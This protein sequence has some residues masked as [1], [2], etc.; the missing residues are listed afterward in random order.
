MSNDKKIVSVANEIRVNNAIVIIGAGV[1]YE[2]GMPLGNQLAPIIW[3]VVSSFPQIDQEFKGIGST[4]NRIGE[5]INKIKKAF[6]FIE[7]NNDAVAL[8]KKMFKRINNKIIT[9]SNIHNNIAKLLHENYFELVVSLNWDS[10]LEMSWSDMYGTE[11][12]DSKINLI[13]PH[14]DVLDIESSWVL[15]NSPGN[16]KIDE[17]KQI[18]SLASERP[19][20]LIIVGYSESDSKI[21]KDLISPLEDKWKVY[22]VSPFPAHEDIIKS[23]ASNFFESLTNHLIDSEKYEAWEHINFKNQNNSLARAILGYKLT[24]QDIVVC[25]EMPQVQ[26]ALKVLDLNNYVILQGKPGSGKSI[27]SYQI[28]YNY[29]K[30]GYEVLRFKTNEFNK[31]DLFSIPTLRKAIYIIDD[32]QILPASL[33]NILQEK[34]NENQKI[35]LTVTDE[36]ETNSA[37]VLISNAENLSHISKFYKENETMISKIVSSIDKDLGPHFMQ[38]SFKNRLKAASKEDNLW[39]FNYVLRGG[40]KTSEDNFFKAKD[41]NNAQRLIFL[42]A[43]KQIITKDNIVK[44]KWFVDKVKEYFFED[45]EWI[46]DTL[47]SLRKKG[48][49]DNTSLRMI[50]Y[51]AAKRQLRIIYSKDIEHRKQYDEI[52][53]EEMLS[54]ENTILGKTWFMN[55][56]FTSEIHD[57]IPEIISK[58]EMHSIIE[59]HL[60]YNEKNELP[61]FLYFI[62]SL[63]RFHRFDY[64]DLYDFSVLIHNQIESVNGL[65]AYS[66]SQVINSLYNSNKKKAKKIGSTLNLNEISYR[67]SNLKKNDLYSWSHFI[68]R[69]NLLLTRGQSRDFFDSLDREKIESELLKLDYNKEDFEALVDFIANIYIYDE[70]YAYKLFEITSMYFRN[71]FNNHS[72]NAWH[73][74]SFSF[75]SIVLGINILGEKR[76]Y[77]KKEQKVVGNKIISFIDPKQLAEE[78]ITVPLRSWHNLSIFYEF[79]RTLNP[80]LYDETIENIDFKK[81]KKKFD[82]YNIWKSSSS[83]VIEFLFLYLGEKNVYRIDNFLYQNKEKFDE[84]TL[85]HFAFSPSLVEYYLKN[86]LSIPICKKE[87]LKDKEIR[88]EWQGLAILIFHLINKNP[89]LLESFLYKQS[90]IIANSISNFEEIDLPTITEV[91]KVLQKFSPQI[92]SEVINHIDLNLLNSKVNKITDPN[93]NSPIKLQKN[94]KKLNILYKYIDEHYS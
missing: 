42:L 82:D 3:D 60:N 54:T 74:L 48:L 10:L 35:I 17:Q 78:I 28:A 62:D 37:T 14:G 49:I 12:N 21:V 58:N 57:R 47:L 36:I 22:R 2:P 73:T 41:I 71:A 46:N 30:R 40:W 9:P 52:I 29:L 26:K 79:L 45:I 19:R 87:F 75:L 85:Y 92:S 89:N 59:K 8:F 56:I 67:V 23:S 39:K 25:P 38:E 63:T 86:N 1:S 32:G 4:K 18:N 6:Y 33:L 7:Q 80:K 61:H 91:L 64:F 16:I 84:L 34:T 15:P 53:K 72:I 43:F 20:T 76:M 77:I 13:K 94:Q 51:E 93:F 11:I 5:D 90:D 27:S 88:I 83:E 44:Q 68:S 70:K 31:K 55:V 81:I 50:H 66:I 65:S 24:P 69:L